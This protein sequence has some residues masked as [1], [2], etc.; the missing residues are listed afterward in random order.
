LLRAYCHTFLTTFTQCTSWFVQLL[1]LAALNLKLRERDYISI[2]RQPDEVNPTIWSPDNYCSIPTPLPM[3]LDWTF[4]LVTPYITNITQNDN[5]LDLPEQKGDSDMSHDYPQTPKPQVDLSQSEFDPRPTDPSNHLDL[6]SLGPNFDSTASLGKIRTK[7]PFVDVDRYLSPVHSLPHDLESL[8]TTDLLTRLSNLIDH[9]ST[10]QKNTT[11]SEPV[12][13]PSSSQHS[14]SSIRHT[15]SDSSRIPKVVAHNSPCDHD[16]HLDALQLMPTQRA[17]TLLNQSLS[18]TNT[19]IGHT[20]GELSDVGE[21][22]TSILFSN[23]H[24]KAQF[25]ENIIAQRLHN[26]SS[27]D[28]QLN[29]PTFGDKLML[30]SCGH[31][32]HIVTWLLSTCDDNTFLSSYSKLDMAPQPTNPSHLLPSLHQNQ[33]P[34]GIS[35][36]L[37]KFLQTPSF[38]MLMTILLPFMS[39]LPDGTKFGACPTCLLFGRSPLIPDEMLQFDTPT[40]H[41][42]GG[43]VNSTL[44]SF[45]IHQQ[46]IQ[47]QLLLLSSLQLTLHKTSLKMV[48]NCR[49]LL[50]TLPSTSQLLAL[51]SHNSLHNDVHFSLYNNHRYFSLL[52]KQRHIFSGASVLE[53]LKSKLSIQNPGSYSLYHQAIFAHQ[54]FIVNPTHS[55]LHDIC[56]T[57]KF[58]DLRRDGNQFRQPI[59]MPSLAISYDPMLILYEDSTKQTLYYLDQHFITTISLLE[60]TYASLSISANT[61]PIRIQ[62][63]PPRPK[64]DH[65]P[66]NQLHNDYF[67]NSSSNGAAMTASS[68]LPSSATLSP[69]KPYQEP[70]VEFLPIPDDIP[71]AFSSIS[72]LLHDHDQYISNSLLFHRLFYLYLLLTNREWC[73]IP[74]LYPAAPDTSTS[75]TSS[76]NLAFNYSPPSPHLRPQSSHQFDSAASH[77]SSAKTMNFQQDS[78][79]LRPVSGLPRSVHID[80]THPEPIHPLEPSGGFSPALPQSPSA[81]PSI[82]PNEETHLDSSPKLVDFSTLFYLYQPTIPTLD[83]LPTTQTLSL[84]L[85]LELFY[86]IETIVLSKS[87]SNQSSSQLFPPPSPHSTTTRHKKS[88]SQDFAASSSKRW[89]TQLSAHFPLIEAETDPHTHDENE[90]L[91]DADGGYENTDIDDPVDTLFAAALKEEAELLQFEI[92][93]YLYHY[94]TIYSINNIMNANFQSS[95]NILHLFRPLAVSPN[96]STLFSSISGDITAQ[97]ICQLSKQSSVPFKLTT[98]ISDADALDLPPPQELVEIP[99]FPTLLPLLS[100]FQLQHVVTMLP[101]ITITKTFAENVLTFKLPQQSHPNSSNVSLIDQ[102]GPY[103]PATKLPSMIISSTL[104]SILSQTAQNFHSSISQSCYTLTRPTL[105]NVIDGVYGFGPISQ[106]PEKKYETTHGVSQSVLKQQHLHKKQSDVHSCLDDLLRGYNESFPAH[107]TP[108]NV[109][110]PSSEVHLATSP[111]PPGNGF[112]NKFHSIIGLDE[113]EIDEFV[114]YQLHGQASNS[115]SHTP[116]PSPQSKSHEHQNLLWKDYLNSGSVFNPLDK[117]YIHHNYDVPT[118]PQNSSLLTDDPTDSPIVVDNPELLN[119]LVYNDNYDPYYESEGFFAQELSHSQQRFVQNTLLAR[120]QRPK[121]LHNVSR[122]QYSL[123]KRSI[124]YQI[125]TTYDEAA[126]KQ[127]LYPITIPLRPAEESTFGRSSHF[128]AFSSSSIHQSVSTYVTGGGDITQ[129]EQIVRFPPENDLGYNYPIDQPHLIDN[130]QTIYALPTVPVPQFIPAIQ[131][132]FHSQYYQQSK[133]S[134]QPTTLL[135]LLS[136]PQLQTNFPAF[137]TVLQYQHHQSNIS[138]NEQ[139]PPP[140]DHNSPSP[141]LPPEIRPFQST[142][143]SDLPPSSPPIRPNMIWNGVEWVTITTTDSPNSPNSTRE[144]LTSDSS[145]DAPPT[146]DDFAVARSLLSLSVIHN[147]PWEQCIDDPTAPTA[148]SPVTSRPTLNILSRPLLWQLASGNSSDELEPFY[149]SDM[150][151]NGSNMDSLTAFSPGVTGSSNENHDNH[152]EDQLDDEGEGEEGLVGLYDVPGFDFDDEFFQTGPEPPFNLLPQQVGLDLLS[153]NSIEADYQPGLVNHDEDANIGSFSGSVNN[154]DDDNRENDHESCSSFLKTIQMPPNIISELQDFTLD[155]LLSLHYHDIYSI[156]PDQHIAS[157]IYLAII[158]ENQ[159]GH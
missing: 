71:T 105:A 58:S 103:G 150:G 83:V 159:K 134:G 118:N 30:P 53:Q 110:P 128:A 76:S 112:L 6:Q 152:E 146:Q 46:S 10:L 59:V 80:L 132:T 157:A 106:L 99:D 154:F 18:E 34:F 135:H 25:V 67:P 73:Q 57:S 85:Y 120:Q 117:H 11:N 121:H 66:R 96:S 149:L 92:H 5:D 54:R 126:D 62:K 31:C 7:F 38:F 68:Y 23:L 74:R 138:L 36:Q 19:L 86:D 28:A 79:L 90:A 50:S 97:H 4:L 27:L 158:K 113:K 24:S 130:T 77:L 2:L 125:D 147:Q 20:S 44:R 95:G 47:N 37:A 108:K 115:P 122:L 143:I 94:H 17:T 55:A 102:S 114:D 82:L 129:F 21:L 26:Q 72:V 39:T 131:S 101:P 9:Y 65:V 123:S 51:Y 124:D 137:Q 140:P 1:S 12:P 139:S 144:S 141:P 98:D 70:P 107:N 153:D 52:L 56:L 127:I 14:F 155:D 142:Q 88:S 136:P 100:P 35:H 81:Q 87:L 16:A 33:H 119:L 111:S 78:K 40:S 3:L 15:N 91:D 49:L 151:D 43:I 104:S 75:R 45:H 13:Q 22:Y 64:Q 93:H 109:P 8:P 116:T 42:L 133:E 32:H 41:N 63:S 69:T 84:Y 145:D 60:E 89:T 148:R 156:I 29:D 48:S 61:S